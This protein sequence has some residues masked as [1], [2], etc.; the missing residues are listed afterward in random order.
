MVKAHVTCPRCGS[1][2]RITGEKWKF[3]VFHVKQYQC[4]S[5]KKHFME[6][7]REGKLIHTV[8]KENSISFLTGF[9][10][11]LYRNRNEKLV[12]F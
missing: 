8:P 12:K 10:K 7:Y 5:C 1:T 11:E 4:L 6:Y 2:A 3:S 9:P